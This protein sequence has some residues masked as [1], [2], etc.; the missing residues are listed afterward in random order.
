MIQLCKVSISTFII[1]SIIVHTQTQCRPLHHHHHHRL[2]KK[3]KRTKEVPGTFHHLNRWTLVALLIVQTHSITHMLLLLLP[4]VFVYHSTIYAHHSLTQHTRTKG[5]SMIRWGPCCYCVAYPPYTRR[6]QVR[7]FFFYFCSMFVVAVDHLIVCLSCSLC[8]Y[9]Y[10]PLSIGICPEKNA[11]NQ[12]HLITHIDLVIQK[13][14]MCLFVCMYVCLLL[15]FLY[16]K[17]WKL[18]YSCDFDWESIVTFQFGCWTLLFPK[19][20]LVYTSFLLFFMCARRCMCVC[21]LYNVHAHI[22]SS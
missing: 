1:T 12:R 5:M 19:V 13:Y 11:L 7:V 4:M 10:Q 2:A 15:I 20:F 22:R 16:W 3:E 8:V 14:Q 21:V 9:S 6:H 18:C 17:T